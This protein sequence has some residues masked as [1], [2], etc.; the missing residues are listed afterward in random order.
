MMHG[1]YRFVNHPGPG[2]AVHQ[3]RAGGGPDPPGS[4]VRDLSVAVR[5]A[6]TATG[7]S[8]LDPDYI[9]SY[10]AGRRLRPR[11]QRLRVR[12]FLTNARVVRS[13]LRMGEAIFRWW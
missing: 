4:G 1:R 13:E 10:V 12:Y 2:A 11:S 5:P 3:R 6:R 8:T 7:P 9:Y